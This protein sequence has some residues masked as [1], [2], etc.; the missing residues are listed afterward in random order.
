MPLE[1]TLPDYTDQVS[2]EFKTQLGQVMDSYLQMKDAFVA[3]N[4]EDAVKASASMLDALQLVDMKLLKGDSHIYWMDKNETL[5]AHAQQIEDREEIDEQRDQF[6]FLSQTSI[7]ALKVMGISS[8]SFYVQHCPMAND[9]EGADWVSKEG[10]VRNPYFGDK[11]L[12]CGFVTDTITE[13]YRN[14]SFSAR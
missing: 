8:D 3:T 1:N 14:K 13:L 6:D 5:Q 12:K 11:M 10:E 7:E 4:N 9:N 2:I